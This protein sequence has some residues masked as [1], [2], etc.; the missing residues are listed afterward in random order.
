M[1]V[2]LVAHD[3]TL[4]ALTPDHGGVG[5]R[6]GDADLQLALRARAPVALAVDNARLHRASEA[7]R[8]QAEAANRS[9]T[10]FLAR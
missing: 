10:E 3:R 7:A 4:G 6:Y 1:I 8:A 9:K 5:R 2:P